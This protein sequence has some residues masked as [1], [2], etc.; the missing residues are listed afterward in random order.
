MWRTSPWGVG[1]DAVLVR[2][3]LLTRLLP[4]TSRLRVVFRA[5]AALVLAAPV[6]VALQTPASASVSFGPKIDFVTG[7]GPYAVASA[8]FD[9]DGRPDM[10]VANTNSDTVSVLLG[11]GM[12][13]FGTKTDFATGSGP[14]SVASADFDRNGA[15]DLAVA[16]ELSDTVSVLL[17]DGAGGFGP[18]ADFATGSGP[19]SV[20]SA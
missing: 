8:D 19:I 14:A 4:R 3:R 11:D 5:L 17:G 1:L 15:P 6:V 7:S 2:R 13:G 10:A 9:R 12:G 20:V 18:R 16:N